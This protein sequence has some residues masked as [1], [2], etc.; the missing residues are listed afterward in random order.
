ML[1]L[2]TS[3]AFGQKE[4]SGSSTKN[5]TSFQKGQLLKIEDFHDLEKTSEKVG[6]LVTIQDGA[7]RY[8]GRYALNYF[9]HDRSKEMNTGEEVDF[10]IDGKHLIV[11]T[12]KGEEIK[13]RLCGQK[14]NCVKCGSA[15]I[16][17]AG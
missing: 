9:Q 7:S 11:K 6:Y 15:V 1:V 10:R 14:G 5:K 13:M 16:C 8:F 3:T 17:G 4:S 12:P 2:L